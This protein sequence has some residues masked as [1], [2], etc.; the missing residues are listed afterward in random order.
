[1]Y[2]GNLYITGHIF[3]FE[4]LTGW[5]VGDLGHE[6]HLPEMSELV[7]LVHVSGHL[8]WGRAAAQQRGYAAHSL[9]RGQTIKLLHDWARRWELDTGNWKLEGKIFK[10]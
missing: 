4:L 7:M 9:S 10:V 8:G 5:K 3:V 1:M 2:Q 6:E